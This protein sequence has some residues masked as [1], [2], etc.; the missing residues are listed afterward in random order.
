MMRKLDWAAGWALVILGATHC[1]FTFA[2][3]KELSGAAMWFFSGGLALIYTGALNL[4]RVNA[5]K[6]AAGWSQFANLSMLLFAMAYAAR[7]GMKAFSDPQVWL[8]LALLGGAA[9][10]SFRR[11]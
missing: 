4:V 11:K 5:G 9:W 8:L 7:R 1:L 3:Y 10:F 6:A 2:Q